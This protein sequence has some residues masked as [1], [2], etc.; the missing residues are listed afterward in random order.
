MMSMRDIKEAQYMVAPN[1]T[2][3]HPFPDLDVLAELGAS[4]KYPGNMHADFMRNR[5]LDVVRCEIRAAMR[6]DIPLKLGPLLT[7]ECPQDII[8]PHA[9]FSDIYHRYPNT[10]KARVAPSPDVFENFW[11]EMT[12]HPLMEHSKLNTREDFRHKAVAL[13][14]HGDG[15]PV[16]G[17]GKSW[18]KMMDIWSW[19][20]VR[21]IPSASI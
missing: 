7:R 16:T 18:A 5:S 1:H 13:R 11:H 14:M 15:V 19:I 20:C 10:W 8:M 4:G 17:V 21:S 12:D 3:D 6:C 9:L 2:C